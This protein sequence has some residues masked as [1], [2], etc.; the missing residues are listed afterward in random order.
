MYVHKS[1]WDQCSVKYKNINNN[2]TNNNNNI[3]NNSVQS[4]EGICDSSV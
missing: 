1:L 4:Q 2:N 3:S